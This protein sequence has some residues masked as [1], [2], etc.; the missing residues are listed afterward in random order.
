MAGA[1][2][3]GARE[4]KLAPPPDAVRHLQAKLDA[5]R[6]ELAD[7]MRGQEAFQAQGA[8]AVRDLIPE[9]GIEAAN[10]DA[11]AYRPPPTRE[12][13]Q[14]SFAKASRRAARAIDMSDAHHNAARLGLQI[15]VLEAEI[16]VLEVRLAEAS[17][18]Q[19]N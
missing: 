2:Q 17:S 3:S 12:E 13:K 14:A 15:E 16:K 10:A 5:K 18:Q 8:E 9:G 19:S 1:F 11:V 6:K 7:L 4:E